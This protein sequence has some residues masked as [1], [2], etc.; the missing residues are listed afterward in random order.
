M[1]EV[2]DEHG[3]MECR[4]VTRLSGSRVLYVWGIAPDDLFISDQSYLHH[5]WRRWAATAEVLK[6][7][8]P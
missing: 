5:G 3:D 4:M 6:V 8:N 7:A 1:L 2:T